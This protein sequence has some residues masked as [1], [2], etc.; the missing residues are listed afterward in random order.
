MVI[1]VTP[2]LLS[3][4][5]KIVFIER[6]YWS[7]DIKMFSIEKVFAEVSRLLPEDGFVSEF[8]RVPY[9]NSAVETIKNLISFKKPKADIYHVTGQINYMALVLPARRTVLTVHD[10]GFLNNGNGGWLRRYLIKKLFLDLPI[11]RLKYITAVSEATRDDIVATAR[12]SP[13]KIRVIENPIQEDYQASG[14]GAFNKDRPTILQVGITENKNIPNLIEALKGISC[15]LKIIGELSGDLVRALTEAR[16]DY[17]SAV[18]LDNEGMK[19]AYEEA[20][21]VAFCS[22]F[23]GFG[24]PI[25]EAQA[26][27]TPVITSNLSP[28]IEVSGGAAYLADPHDAASIREGILKIIS[29]D[30]FR[31]SITRQGLENVKRFQPAAISKQYQ[32][33]YMEMLEG[34]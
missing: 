20:D 3:M 28:M 19:A 31:E 12:C 18:A 33:L 21:I 27:R 26:M 4:T 1:I 30:E 34:K 32:D 9:G 13:D 23:E 16:I 5:T 22:T 14:R 17:E 8:V 25:I 15:R 24:L 11:R 29:D 2:R 7:K 10:L 6:K